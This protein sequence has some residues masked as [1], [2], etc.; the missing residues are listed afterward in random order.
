MATC[1]GSN[2][3]RVVVVQASWQGSGIGWKQRLP[4]DNVVEQCWHRGH[5]LRRRQRLPGTEGVLRV[6][7]VSSETSASLVKELRSLVGLFLTSLINLD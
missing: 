7:S 2:F 5:Q 6:N 1:N 4:D 3:S